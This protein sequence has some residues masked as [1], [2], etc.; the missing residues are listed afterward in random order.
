MGTNGT[1]GTNGAVFVA[2]PVDNDP[3]S[4]AINPKLKEDISGGG[5]GDGVVAIITPITPP[6]ASIGLG[7]KGGKRVGTAPLEGDPADKA[8]DDVVAASDPLQVSP[9]YKAPRSLEG[10]ITASS[11][12]EGAISNK[13]IKT[14]LEEMTQSQICPFIKRDEV[15]EPSNKKDATSK[16]E[17]VGIYKTIDLISEGPIAGLCDSKGNLIPIIEGDSPSNE[18]MLK[19]VYLNDV[20]VINTYG[21][22]LNYQR[23]HSEIK[24]GTLYQGLLQN[25]K[26]KALSFLRSS[27]TFNIGLSMPGQNKEQTDAF[28]QG[29]WDPSWYVGSAQSGYQKGFFANLTKPGATREVPMNIKVG[30]ESDG[31]NTTTIMG[32]VVAYT[33]LYE[34]NIYSDEYSG[35]VEEGGGGSGQ[36]KKNI[37]NQVLT[38]GSGA[39]DVSIYTDMAGLNDGMVTRI[40]RVFKEQPV[41]FHHAITNDN[42]SDIEVTVAVDSL[43]LRRME[44][45]AS[46]DPMNNTIIFLIK[47][48]YEDSDRLI[49]DGG[50]TFYAMA[51]VSGLSTSSYKRSYTFPLPVAAADR[52]RRISVCVATEEPTPQAKAIG[53]VQRAG[54]VSTVTE[55]IEAPLTF[56]HS[57]L[58]ATLIDARSFSRVPKRTYD[59]KL[60]KIKIPANYDSENREYFG[61]W[62]GQWAPYKQWSDN[63]AWIFYDMM[64]SQRYG[65]QKYGFGQD[66]VDKWNL[67]SI[68]KYCD[69][70]V[71]TG[72]RPANIPLSFSIDPNGVVV[73][74]PDTLTEGGESKLRSL[75]PEGKIISLYK[76]KDKD[77]VAI[78]RGYRR[79]IG[80]GAY[81]TVSKVYSFPIHKIIHS[82]YIFETYEGLRGLWYDD[83]NRLSHDDR[84]TALAWIYQYLRKE[85]SENSASEVVKDYTD[86]FSLGSTVR[87]GSVVTELDLHKPVLEPRFSTNV[88]L[89]REQDAM[90]CLNDLAAVFRGMVY[91]NS[92]FV[93]ISN[94]QFRESVMLFNN[95]SV[96]DGV[97]TYTGSSKSTRF[98]SVLV[99]YNDAYD[100][101]KPKVEYVEDAASIRKYGYLEKKIVALGTTS[102]SQA[103]RLGKWFLFTNQLE[104]DLVQFKAGIEATYLRPGDVIKIQ[105]GLKNTKRYGGR[106]KAISPSDY[107]LTLDQGVYE[108][109]VGQTITLIVPAA[110]RSVSALN[111]EAQVQMGEGNFTGIPQEKI[112]ETRATQ[113]KQFTVAAVSGS[114]ANSGG[115]QNDVITV[116]ESEEFGKVAVGTIWSLQNT[117]T[118]VN[119]TEVSYRILTVAEETSGEYSVTAMMYEGSK[120]GAVDESRDLTPTQQSNPTSTP[121][122]PVIGEIDWDTII[123]STEFD[124]VQPNRVPVGNKILEKDSMASPDDSGYNEEVEKVSVWV[125][126]SAV[127]ELLVAQLGK[128]N[129]KAYQDELGS[130]TVNLDAQKN[131]GHILIDISISRHI[132]WNFNVVGGKIERKTG[133]EGNVKGKSVHLSTFTG[134]SEGRHKKIYVQVPKGSKQLSVNVRLQDYRGKITDSSSQ[135]VEIPSP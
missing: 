4:T 9:Y 131:D 133:G 41:V 35:D 130:S 39:N 7:E 65:L 19:G 93:F 90:N 74:V 134:I 3:V 71:E 77:G 27:Q 14:R 2:P 57:A 44:P 47:I 68:A 80:A 24:Y 59:M 34:T 29:D 8:R 96:R 100:S 11:D 30:T 1:N 64:T 37:T 114:D 117:S 121:A 89:D 86:G 42:V 91:W 50:G 98:T 78:N 88:Y 124:I 60:L 40:R 92:G 67:Y 16:L 10:V 116:E 70:L 109:I 6:E 28:M 21:G 66:I 128:L 33:G 31:R 72:Y 51:P 127:L 102:R 22:T 129:L 135:I 73:S 12:T 112:D 81:D 85:I 26:Q 58:M 46:K 36:A 118:E 107:Q 23:I 49:G 53:A 62:T 75:F 113:I 82:E 122:G 83:N 61:N 84:L 94:D 18:N 132:Y 108:D 76:L 54:G 105:D 111:E 25:H 97:F 15:S 87:T 13:V 55:I 69:E 115:V 63:P 106:I 125:N 99:R 52:D 110:S 126:L 38:I 79:R 5:Q 101:Y 32:N 120:F 56:P 48:G 45:S 20:P 95:S 103:Y 43:Y 104:T 17:S 119:I 123:G